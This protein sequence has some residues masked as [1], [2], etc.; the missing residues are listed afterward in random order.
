MKKFKQLINPHSHSDYS[1]D[2]AAT[3]A[4]IIK[5][6]IEL[7]ASYV[8]ITEHGNMNS[9]MELYKNI[10]DKKIVGDVNAKPILGIEAYMENPFLDYYIAA[11]KKA[12][13]F[14]QL[15]LKS[16]SPDKIEQ[17]IINKARHVSYTHLTIHFK[18]E[19][20]YLY[21]CK[22]SPKMWDRALKKYDE[23]KPIILFDELKPIAKHI[24]I[25]SSC[26]K[27]P[28][29]QF[30]MP[31]RDGIIQPNPDLAEKMYC[32]LRDLV[33]PDDFFVE[34]FPHK[35]THEW[36][37][38]Q[39]D[40]DTK[41]IIKNGYFKQNECTCH[42]PDGDLQKPLN[43]FVLGLANKYKDKVLIS[44]DS[45]FATPNQKVI[46]DAKLGNGLEAWK[47][48]E[49][50]HIFSSDEAA[51]RLKS[52]LNVSD[53]D[54]EEWIDNSYYWAEK[55]KDFKLTTSKERWILKNSAD[56][57]FSRL[58]TTIE[59]YG[60]MDWNNL[61]M[62]ERL[63]YEIKV[64]AHNGKI[65]LL[66]YFEIVEDIANFCKA[67]DILIN[68]RGSAA[69]C[70]LLY[71]IGVSSINPLK[72]GLS[73]ERF[74]TEGRIKANTLP[75]VD[76]D[77]SDR[78]AVIKY[79]EEKYGDRVC[80]LS[81]DILL[82]LKSAIKDAERAFLGFV[83]PETEKMCTKL[84]NTPQGVEDRKF[85]FG[86]TDDNGDHHVGIFETSVELQ[87]YAK[88]NPELWQVITEMLGIQ[89]NKST[90]AC[91]LIITDKPVYEYMPVIKVNKDWATGFSPKSVE[92]AGGVKYDILGVNTLRD[93][94]ECLKSIKKRFG[95]ALDVW[96]LPYD[97]KVF[98]AFG[99]GD[100]V[101]V[102]QFD[103]VTVR[104]FVTAIKP[105]SIDDLAAITAL[106]RPGTLDAPSDEPNVTLAQAYIHRAKGKPIKY[107]HPDLEPILKETMG[108]QL[109]QEQTLR[110]YRDIGGFKYEE[111]ETVRRG[112][113]KKDEAILA[114][115]TKRLKE[116]CLKKGWTEEQV[117]LLIEQIMASARYSF[118]KSH[119]VSYAY[120]SYICMWLKINY[121]LDWWL[122]ILTNSSKD[123]I[124]SKF[125][126][127]V[128][129]Y[130]V[131]PDINN[132][133]ANWTILGDKIIA[134]IPIIIG[135]GPKTYESLIAGK[136][137]KDLRAFV[138]Y[139][140]GPNN[141]SA[142]NS[143]AVR[144]LVAAG[145]MDSLFDKNLNIT[146]KL[147][148]FEKI[149]AEVKDTTK[150]EA[151]PEEFCNVTSI[152]QYLLRKQLLNIYSEDLRPLVLPQ[153]G[154]KRLPSK[155]NPDY[156]FWVTQGGVVVLDGV[157]LD[158]I[159]QCIQNKAFL[160]MTAKLE[161]IM[162]KNI[163]ITVNGGK[164][165]IVGGLA[166]VLDEK[167][168]LYSGKTKQATKLVLDINGYFTEEIIWPQNDNPIAP[169]GFKNKICLVT[170]KLHNEK[171]SLLT[172]TT[173][174]DPTRVKNPYSL[175]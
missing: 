117:N 67:N 145:V 173:V 52:T 50:Y 160:E 34:I 172:I 2:G 15:K 70:L 149:K 51:A 134:P 118:N 5:R 100:T 54:I 28:V 73:F 87:E 165:Y 119:A 104:P 4:Q 47:F 141:Q 128:Q 140:F 171:M 20:A 46:Q 123:E 79:L 76:I 72:H 115:S 158:W 147:Q 92:M 75:D 85:L 22:L 164:T 45:H 94:Q 41:R 71:V 91:G 163:E 8:C 162:P 9:A 33:G 133:E 132:S 161:A 156:Y 43:Q 74:L 150:V 83:R 90:H 36:Q 155:R 121:P 111:A 69:G 130:V 63:K 16:K 97:E 19:E 93:I 127:E 129:D 144:K 3:V 137:Y 138:E 58:K 29:Q 106:C 151:I 38:P 55:F 114:E 24:T 175:N 13:Q 86:Y 159:R 30:L 6:N 60:R 82:K 21:F 95:I 65:N 26:M 64:L 168:L 154:G 48:Y 152:G 148:L 10:Y 32:M 112:I 146:E 84:P 61:E 113:G 170:Y 56:E 35:V 42:F 49:S 122:A 101:S 167:P 136:P 89:R 39:L 18:D 66:S 7:G 62:V 120:V 23:L 31:S 107:I 98:E 27:G 124:A 68:V 153:R 105:K 40:N 25:T 53:R 126:R 77:V 102:F 157:Q 125:W 11:Y 116:S 135:I 12:Y 37:K 108:I 78:D 169:H 99:R 17:E 142:V 88:R 44:L 14:G 110:I 80:R 109:Y 1:L 131:L 59:K 96:N 143:G 103:T 166:Y 57:F 81:T 139:H 174:I